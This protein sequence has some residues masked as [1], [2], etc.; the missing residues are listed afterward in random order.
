MQAKIQGQHRRF[1]EDNDVDL[2]NVGRAWSS[3]ESQLPTLALTVDGNHPSLA[4][5]YIEAL[6]IY[7]YLSDR[8]L[9]VAAYRPDGM[10]VT[11]AESIASEIERRISSKLRL[12]AALPP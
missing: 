11:D 4:G 3:I 2:I 10:S 6:A 12:R 7:R 5:S 9:V 8:S 1:A